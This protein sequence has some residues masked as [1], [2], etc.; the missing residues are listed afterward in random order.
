MPAG[1]MER[2]DRAD[3]E[4]DLQGR[5]GTL[6][7]NDR[8][9]AA[10][11]LDAMGDMPG[12]ALVA[13]MGEL[14]RSEALFE[15]VAGGTHPGRLVRLE[16]DD[17]LLVDVF[18]FLDLVMPAWGIRRELE[19]VEMVERVLDRRLDLAARRSPARVPRRL[20][21]GGDDED[22]GLLLDGTADERGRV[23]TVTAVEG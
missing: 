6:L 11:D 12:E 20:L 19:D 15:L 2:E 14:A 18:P 23:A 13:V 9:A 8:P 16:A 21:P 17:D 1:A 10:V 3:G 7:R 5:V 4:V 22:M